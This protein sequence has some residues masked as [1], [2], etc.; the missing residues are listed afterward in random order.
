MQIKDVKV[1]LHLFFFGNDIYSANTID[2][3]VLPDVIRFCL[4]NE[5]IDVVW[6]E[7][8]RLYRILPKGKQ[9]LS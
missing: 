2:R 7:E 1:F 6:K 5:I 4:E 3:K 8:T 9:M